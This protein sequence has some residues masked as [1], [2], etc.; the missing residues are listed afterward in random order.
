MD[1]RGTRLLAVIA[2]VITLACGGFAV[3]MAATSE[4]DAD[5]GGAPSA[6]APAEGAVAVDIA[7]FAFDP[8]PVSVPVGGAITWT[9]RDG[10]AH[11]VRSDDGALASSPIDQGQTY[12][13]TFAAAG[14]IAY[15]CGIHPSMTGTVTVTP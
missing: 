6:S 12:T 3:A 13:A 11:S 1:G 14:E 4:D 5:S 8:N 7:D 9:N 10:L 2:G 15:Y